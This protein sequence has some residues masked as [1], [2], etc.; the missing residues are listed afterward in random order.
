MFRK[1]ITSLLYITLAA[2][3][4]S[5]LATNPAGAQDQVDPQREADLKGLFARHYDPNSLGKWGEVLTRERIDYVSYARLRA[6]D[7]TGMTHEFSWSGDVGLNK[8]GYTNGNI[9]YEMAFDFAASVGP[10]RLQADVRTSMPLALWRNPVNEQF[11]G[12]SAALRQPMAVCNATI[13]QVG[14][15]LAL[16]GDPLHEQYTFGTG[17]DAWSIAYTLRAEQYGIPGMPSTVLAIAESDPFTLPDGDAGVEARMKTVSILD[18]GMDTLY[19]QATSFEAIKAATGERMELELLIR[20]LRL[21]TTDVVDV[22]TPRGAFKAGLAQMQPPT[23]TGVA[24]TAADWEKLPGWA[25]ASINGMNAANLVASAAVERKTNPLL[26]MAI[27]IVVAADTVIR[28]TTDTDL[29]GVM[30]DSWGAIGRGSGEAFSSVTGVPVDVDQWESIGEGFGGA[31]GE[32]LMTITTNVSPVAGTVDIVVELVDDSTSGAYETEP[33]P[34]ID[35][36]D[37]L[38][39]GFTLLGNEELTEAWTVVNGTLGSVSTFYGDNAEVSNGTCVDGSETL[40]QGTAW[41]T[42]SP[43]TVND[44]TWVTFL[45]PAVL[46]LSRQLAMN[47]VDVFFLADN[48]GSMNVEIAEVRDR[49]LAILDALAGSDPRFAD[50]DINWGVGRYSD[51][52]ITDP[53]DPGYELMQPITSVATDV[54]LQLGEWDS[55]WGS[56]V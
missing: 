11:L 9:L 2:L 17:P 46:D 7:S 27:T 12:G 44:V 37:M 15:A 6:G 3:L 36:T 1:P 55:T 8:L 22:G 42:G 43:N 30:A 34:G 51:D 24:P 19:Y 25:T 26:T 33:P 50:V 53:G 18:G 21:G 31:S 48:T 45:Q 4:G 28:L 52:Q 32:V 13:E 54:A 38:N 47:Q 5:A 23:Q 20:R 14:G 41:Y 49:A 29:K 35:A 16:G 10:N 56:D 40:Y 39:L